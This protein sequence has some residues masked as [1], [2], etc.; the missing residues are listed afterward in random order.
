M[1]GIG[2]V[3]PVENRLP[4]EGRQPAERDGGKAPRR[5]RKPD[6]DEMVE[7]EEHKLDLEA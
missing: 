2:T 3:A 7:V 1:S 4:V 6:A 5:P